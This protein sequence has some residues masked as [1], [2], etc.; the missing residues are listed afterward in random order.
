MDEQKPKPV[1]NQKVATK[2]RKPHKVTGVSFRLTNEEIASLGLNPTTQA[3]EAINEVRKRAGLPALAR[4]LQER[5]AAHGLPSTMSAT[6][7]TKWLERQVASKE[8][9]KEGASQ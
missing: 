8:S 6:E 2:E 4:N 9:N 7:Y 1:N 5:L 3:R